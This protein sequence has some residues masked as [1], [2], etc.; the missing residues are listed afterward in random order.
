MFKYNVQIQ[1]VSGSLNES[2][3]PSK[4]LVVKSKTKK[5]DK[6]VFAEASKFYKEKY[7][8]VIESAEV[9]KDSHY[10]PA[11]PDEFKKKCGELALSFEEERDDGYNDGIHSILSGLHSL[12]NLY[13]K[14]NFSCHPGFIE[15]ELRTVMQGFSKLNLEKLIDAKNTV[16]QMYNEVEGFIDERASWDAEE[17]K[18]RRAN[19]YPRL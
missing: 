14:R 8:L 12:A 7:G 15:R 2:A 9:T 18:K 1:K 16:E 17:Q 19:N 11:I 4:N 3:M 6:E 10:G 5:S 13:T